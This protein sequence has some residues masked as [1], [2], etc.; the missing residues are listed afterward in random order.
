MK[1]MT[2]Q[3]E[4]IRRLSRR[5]LFW[6]GMVALAAMPVY[7]FFRELVPTADGDRIWRMVEGGIWFYRRSLLAQASARLIYVCVAPFGG[8]GIDALHIYS[9]LSGG[10]FVFSSVLLARI[11][12]HRC[13]WGLFL[14][15]TGGFGR[16]F[17]GHIEYY[18]LIVALT[19]IYLLVGI[20]ALDRRISLFWVGLAYSLLCWA[21]LMGW[22][23]FP[24]TLL[25]WALLGGEKRAARD[26]ALG[27]IPLGLIFVFLKGAKFIGVDLHGQLYGQHLLRIFDVG[28]TGMWYPFFSVR[29]FR[30]WI[31]IQLTCGAMYWPL[32]LIALSRK[33]AIFI[34]KDRFMLF[35]VSV[36][37]LYL[38]Y[39]LIWHI[40][41]GPQNDWDLFSP[42][43]APMAWIVGVSLH[44][45]QIPRPIVLTL[46]GCVLICGLM[47]V[48][49]A[50]GNAKIGFRGTGAVEIIGWENTRVEIYLDGRRHPRRIEGIA[51]GSHELRVLAKKKGI[52]HRQDIGI[53]PGGYVRV[54]LPP[55]D[56]EAQ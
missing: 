8:S 42:L 11:F 37:L 16:V 26:L 30:E 49:K 33:T 4:A 28:D 15:L 31:E 51:M 55:M 35:T 41:L 18:A 54:T 56:N 50:S 45:R 39:S 32:L 53:G 27:L 46:I 13:A 36:W 6:A 48:M 44:R 17:C 5:D 38:G 22:F 14:L 52:A 34:W 40:D 47:D 23:L 2:C 29:H 10:L 21:H 1:P 9:V 25:I 7:W 3:F 12:P 43:F 19:Q 20:L 24:S